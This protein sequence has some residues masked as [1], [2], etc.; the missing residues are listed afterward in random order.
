MK[1]INIIQEY[2]LT[3]GRKDVFYASFDID[4]KFA[5]TVLSDEEIREYNNRYNV[6]P[7]P[8]INRGGYHYCEHCHTIMLVNDMRDVNTGT[9]AL[10]YYYLCPDCFD[11]AVEDDQLFYCDDCGSV[12]DNIDAMTC[13]QGDDICW[14]VCP[15]CVDNYK[16]CVYCHKLRRR[17]DLTHLDEG[18]ACEDCRTHGH[19]WEYCAHCDDP[20]DVDSMVYDEGED[21]WYC[22]WCW[23]DKIL[24]Y[25]KGVIPLENERNSKNLLP[26]MTLPDEPDH[27]RFI[28]M[29]LEYDY[30][31]DEFEDDARDSLFDMLNHAGLIGTVKVVDDPAVDGKVVTAP[32]SLEYLYQEGGKMES[33]L[34]SMKDFGCSAL[35]GGLGGYIHVDSYGL[36][37]CDKQLVA[38]VANYCHGFFNIIGGHDGTRFLDH[39]GFHYEMPDRYGDCPA[40]PTCAVYIDATFDTIGFRFWS[41]SLNIKVL[42][43]RAAFCQYMVD[44][45]RG[46]T[47]SHDITEEFPSRDRYTE[48][49]EARYYK[50][51][52]RFLHY[53]EKQKHGDEV[54]RYLKWIVSKKSPIFRKEEV[55]SVPLYDVLEYVLNK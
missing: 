22:H 23:E 11:K 51:L 34:K 35:Y 31:G 21:R 46:Y 52:M 55:F 17:A 13:I 15:K 18:D 9:G 53:V 54:F 29:G 45:C 26:F 42:R 28:E 27:Y 33:V 3:D 10:D 37:E 41:S 7:R 12:W 25:T 48:Q 4:A 30:V 39:I 6:A 8:V 49:G 19:R 47:E 36:S 16:E 38:N 50:F 1:K 40:G 14:D 20:F 43:V 24:D 5:G 32:M 44:Y 2:H